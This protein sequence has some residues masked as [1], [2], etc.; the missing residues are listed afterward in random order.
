[1]PAPPASAVVVDEWPLVRLGIGQ[2]L[3]GLDIKV[4]AE[5][6]TGADAARR[7]GELGAGWLILGTHRDVP[8]ADVVRR[9]QA[10]GGDRSPRVMVLLDHVSRDALAGLLGLGVDAL[11]VRSARP[12]EVA[13]AVRRVVRGERVVAPALLPLLVGVLGSMPDAE[14]AESDGLLTRKE[15]EVLGRLAEGLSN[16]DIA[17]ALF[18]TSATV[19]THL[20]H[21]YTKLGVTGR[22]EAVAR[23]VELGL[24]G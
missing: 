13:D 23:A 24:L 19:K 6:S 12:E 7:A 16:K 14:Q 21:I 22:Q 11:L 20:A 2:A 8:A 18:V 1:M 15:L 5:L 4:V 10:I 17:D 9:S 3:R